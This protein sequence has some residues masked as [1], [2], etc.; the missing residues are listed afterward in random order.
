[1]LPQNNGFTL[2]KVFQLCCD[3]QL[4][5]LQYPQN[6][7]KNH[8]DP[9]R[10]V[11]HHPNFF[12]LL[13]IRNGSLYLNGTFNLKEVSLSRRLA[14][15]PHSSPGRKKRIAHRCVQAWGSASTECIMG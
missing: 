3:W 15:A 9:W 8:V 2:C 11:Q 4:I 6:E 7:K 1:M 5:F 14:F 13:F 10:Y 12:F